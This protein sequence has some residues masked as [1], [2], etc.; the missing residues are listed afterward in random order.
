MSGLIWAGSRSVTSSGNS[1]MVSLPK[2]EL[3]ERGVRDSDIDDLSI[4]MKVE[5]GQLV[6][7]LDELLEET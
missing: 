1:W 6:A 4:R 2:K 5:D 7:D 3:K